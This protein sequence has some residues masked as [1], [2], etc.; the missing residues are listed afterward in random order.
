[1]VRLWGWSAPQL[2]GDT[3]LKLYYLAFFAAL[4]CLFPYY[5]V[6]Y[7]KRGFTEKQIGILTS[8]RPWVSAL[9]GASAPMPHHQAPPS[10]RQH[11]L[12]RCRCL[13]M[14]PRCFCRRVCPLCHPALRP[15]RHNNLCSSYCTR[16]ALKHRWGTFWSA[17]RHCCHGHG[18]FGT[19]TPHMTNK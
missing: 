10:T 3:I 16:G 13:A 19:W 5:N 7:A 14:S 11:P 8:I 9:A 12:G 6:Y 2:G 17:C 4:V 15:R 1:M 18:Y